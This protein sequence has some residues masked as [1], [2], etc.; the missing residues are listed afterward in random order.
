MLVN[1]QLQATLAT[2]V[3]SVPTSEAQCAMG[4]IWKRSVPSRLAIRSCLH[5]L[6]QNQIT[7]PFLFLAPPSSKCSDLRISGILIDLQLCSICRLKTQ[8][9]SFCR[10]KF[11]LPTVILIPVPAALRLS[12]QRMLTVL[13]LSFCGVAASEISWRRQASFK[14]F[15]CRTAHPRRHKINLDARESDPG[16]C[17]SLWIFFF[18]NHQYASLCMKN[19]LCRCA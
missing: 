7:W 2:S 19:E 9:Q 5:F 6:L 3:F 11:H 1:R 12:R 10:K 8:C 18:V 15:H 14:N 4:L 16:S 17:H 13:L